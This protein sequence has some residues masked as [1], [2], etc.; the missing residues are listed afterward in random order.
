MR[1]N[2]KMRCC[3]HV[4]Y[5][6]W[7]HYSRHQGTKSLL[8]RVLDKLYLY[9]IKNDGS[10]CLNLWCENIDPQCHVVVSEYMV[11][12]LGICEEDMKHHDNEV[13]AKYNDNDYETNNYVI[14]ILLK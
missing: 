8:S 11:F 9:I 14:K 3:L 6:W 13:D 10:I 7:L 12:P 4:E 5:V 1:P 2:K